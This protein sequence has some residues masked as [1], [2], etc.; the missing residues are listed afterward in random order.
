MLLSG[1][2]T[3]PGAA[4]C[5]ARAVA[6]LAKASVGMAAT[7]AMAMIAEEA[8]TTRLRCAMIEPF[9][10]KLFWSHASSLVGLKQGQLLQKSHG[11]AF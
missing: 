3:G 5:A 7:D 9:S 10:A 11:H 6:F 4:A 2:T 1:T 8:S